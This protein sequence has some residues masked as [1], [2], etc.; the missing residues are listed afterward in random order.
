MFQTGQGFSRSFGN[1]SG[2]AKLKMVVG[3]YGGVVNIS[4]VEKGGSKVIVKIPMCGDL[5]KYSSRMWII[6]I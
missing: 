3:F 2:L 4:A 5:N 1:G 6:K